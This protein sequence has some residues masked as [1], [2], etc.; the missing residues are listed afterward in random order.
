MATR[1][2]NRKILFGFHRSNCWP[3]G[4][5]IIEKS[6]PAF[7]GQTDGGISNAAQN[8]RQSYK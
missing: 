6:Y 8:G 1:A 2:I 4:R 3:P 7:T 5:D